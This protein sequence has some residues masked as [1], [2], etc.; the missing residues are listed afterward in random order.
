MNLTE[1]HA[2]KEHALSGPTTGTVSTSLDD[3]LFIVFPIHSFELHI[4]LLLG[5]SCLLVF[6]CCPQGSKSRRKLTLIRVILSMHFFRGAF[7]IA[8]PP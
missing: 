3:Y 5:C 1:S 7:N 4:T 2:G 8:L 6:M